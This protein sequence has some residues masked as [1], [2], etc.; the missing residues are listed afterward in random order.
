MWFVYIVNDPDLHIATA[1]PVDRFGDITFSDGEF[2]LWGREDQP[3]IG[4]GRTFGAICLSIVEASE[5]P[6]KLLLLA[7]TAAAYN[8]NRREETS[9]NEGVSA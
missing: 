4:D 1:V 9:E 6:S 3:S 5:V 7:K 2:N 8:E